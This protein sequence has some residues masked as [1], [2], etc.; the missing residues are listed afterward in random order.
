MRAWTVAFV[1]ALA[2]VAG[3]CTMVVEIAAVR[4]LAPWFG[5]SSIVWT[6]VICVVLLALALGYLAG[7]RLAQGRDP[8]RQLAWV[9]LIGAGSIAWLPALAAPVCA[10]FLPAGVTLDSAAELLTW[11]SLAAASI[12][13]LPGA[14]TL[15][16]IAPLAVE[17]VQRVE[18]SHAGRA[19]GQVLCASTL[20]SLAGAFAATHWLV[21]RGLSATFVEAAAALAVLGA[22]LVAVSWRAAPGSALAAVACLASAG[23]LAAAASQS[24]LQAPPPPDGV[25]LLAE[26]ESS[27]QRLRVVEDRR[28]GAAMRLLQ[29][30]E[31]LDS[32]QSVWAPA[33]GLLGQGFYYDYFALPAWWSRA[34]GE[35]RVLVVGLGAGTTFRV[36]EGASPPGVELDLWGIELDPRA[37]ELGERWFDLTPGPRRRVLA[38]QDG[39]A[40]LRALPRDFDLIV[41]DAYA[42][43]T[44]IPPHLATVEALGEM[45]THLADGGWIAI[46][47]GG[48]GFDDPVVAAVG[49]T[50]C[51]AFSSRSIAYRVPRSRN[52]V[53]IARRGASAPVPGDGA[54]EFAG[55]VGD[56]L[57][58]PLALDA[59]WRGLDRASGVVLS[60]DRNPIEA[61]QQRSLEEGRERLL[62]G[63]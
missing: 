17:W 40:A 34:Q 51:A 19:G 43:Q 52:F 31:G 18:T 16:C 44:E 62:A 28:F 32:F 9:S 29:V 60:D 2:A 4:L 25:E 35:W 1:L 48:F 57:L 36:L 41:L 23:H 15:G 27:Y 13:F 47:V 42:N 39:R 6:N 8:A 33:P 55:P 5:T 38:G 50:L 10:S 30:N 45:R 22:L 46:N 37:I 56:A 24:R 3:A 26:V 11:G 20:G 53:W 58:P 7:A 49:N 21:P 14:A 61:L 59:S 63:P 54:W 12:L